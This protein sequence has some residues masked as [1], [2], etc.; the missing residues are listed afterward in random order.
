MFSRLVSRNFRLFSDI[1]FPDS[2]GYPAGSNVF[3]P[4][5]FS[6][7]KKSVNFAPQDSE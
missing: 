7:M 4:T 6:L 2:V 5:D 3:H 1:M